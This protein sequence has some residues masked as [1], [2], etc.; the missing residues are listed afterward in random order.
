MMRYYRWFPAMVVAVVVTVLAAAGCGTPAR[1]E[2][3][4]PGTPQDMAVQ[5]ACARPGTPLGAR[6][7]RAAYHAPRSPDRGITGAGSVIAVIIPSAAPHVDSDIAVYSARY[8]LPAPKVRVLTYGTVPPS[9]PGDAGPE[10]EGT[11]DLE[12][13]HALAPEAGLVY[14]AVAGA[15]GATGAVTYDNALAWLVTHYRITVVNYSVG[16]PEDWAAPNV[17]AQDGYGVITGSRG[18]LKA[19]VRAGVTV[20]A[21]AGDHGADE[22][23]ADGGFQRTVTW[24]ADDPLV[25]AVGGTRLT[26]VGTG[27]SPS[28]VSSVW[29]YDGIGAGGGG[30]SAIFGRPSWQNGA[31]SVTGTRRGVPDIA[32]D[33]SMCSPVAAYT[34]TNVLPGQVPGWVYEAG[35]SVAAP[36]FAGA[37]AD[38]AQAAGQPLGALGPALYQLHGAADGITDVASGTTSLPGIPGYPARPGY[39][40]TT[41]IGTISSIPLFSRALARLAGSRP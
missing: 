24:P 28:Y 14:L 1:R 16:I 6:E 18:G 30:L 22:P 40:L 11:L 21:S 12:M 37:V 26:A 39:D 20:V 15:T 19:A 27:G 33:A 3:S 34:S 25:T 17:P 13:A 35:S 5:P 10:E 38:A 4:A 32:M 36:L 9:G 7:L 31:R 2:Q 41:G 8:G 23:R 29:G